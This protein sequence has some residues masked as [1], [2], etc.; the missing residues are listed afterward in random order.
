MELDHTLL[1]ALN[2]ATKYPS[3]PTSP[4][5]GAVTRARC[6]CRKRSSTNST[7]TNVTGHWIR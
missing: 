3:I 7:K 5:T 1:A 4:T 6:G 2:T